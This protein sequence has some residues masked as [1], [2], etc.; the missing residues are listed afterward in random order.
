MRKAILPSFM[1]IFSISVAFAMESG[2]NS[3]GNYKTALGAVK[4]YT[5]LLEQAVV[6]YDLSNAI[7]Y[8]RALSELVMTGKVSNP[9]SRPV[10]GGQKLPKIKEF[11][12]G[13]GKRRA[14]AIEK[15]VIYKALDALAM[16]P[17]LQGYLSY[18]GLGKEASKFNIYKIVKKPENKEPSYA[19]QLAVYNYLKKQIKKTSIPEL[20]EK[21]VDLYRLFRAA[22]PGV[23][24]MPKSR[25]VEY[26][27]ST[28]NGIIHAPYFK[29]L[30]PYNNNDK[31]NKLYPW[32]G[33]IRFYFSEGNPKGI[34]FVGIS[35]EEAKEEKEG[36]APPA[37]TIDKADKLALSAFKSFIEANTKNL[38]ISEAR[39]E[40]LIKDPLLTLSLLGNSEMLP[41]EVYGGLFYY[42]IL[43]LSPSDKRV[44]VDWINDKDK[45]RQLTSNQKA[46][47]SQWLEEDFNPEN[48]N[49][50]KVKVKLR[51]FI[52]MGIK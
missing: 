6:Q 42:V 20:N 13:I 30:V 26:Q 11:K 50:S 34:K 19:H 48:L 10:F 32:I 29:Y 46:C 44:V 2:V 18:V 3:E 33:A 8:A 15:L 1:I 7:L 23:K 17:L 14:T 39:L 47:I 21:S 45:F 49:P 36:K 12:Y 9:D 27:T 40:R 37:T 41:P 43:A 35:V 31:L 25:I 24:L 4:G 38:N 16:V 52:T 5:S 51:Y 28:Y 22:D